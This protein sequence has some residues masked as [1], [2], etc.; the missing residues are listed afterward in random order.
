M[1]DTSPN[2]Y[3]RLLAVQKS[4]EY[5]RKDQVQERGIKSVSSSQ[6]IASVRDAMN[7]NGL[8]LSV[9]VNEH[10]LLAKWGNHDAKEHLTELGITFTWV[11]SDN[12]A[13][14]EAF[15]FYGQGLD[16]GEKG[17]G[18]ALTYA[19]KYFLLKFF[20]I[21]TDVDDPDAFQNKTEAAKP[22]N[23][24]PIGEDGKKRIL[25]QQRRIAQATGQP[26][27]AIV[28]CTDQFKQRCGKMALAALLPAEEEALGFELAEFT[29]QALA[30]KQAAPPP[31]RQPDFR[32]DGTPIERPITVP[33]LFPEGDLTPYPAWRSIC[34]ELGIG[35]AQQVA[36]RS[37]V[38]GSERPP[39][40]PEEMG[41]LI[42]A[43][44]AARTA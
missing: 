31:A 2:L 32:A 24:R 3:Q 40:T 9:A 22:V 30:Q 13:D 11:N 10:A 21:P 44:E 5:L 38:F 29:Q 16:T 19:E 1:S 42:A 26:M 37:Q 41:K 34:D 12:P 39:Q 6:V 18:K 4:V 27:E 14:R 33:T 20:H 8:V 25:W 35:I 7:T 43:T 23:E 28:A 15:P 17:V 36:L